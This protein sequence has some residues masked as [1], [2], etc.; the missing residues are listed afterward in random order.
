MNIDTPVSIAIT[1]TCGRIYCL[2]LDR[3]RTER[4]AKNALMQYSQ[5]IRVYSAVIKTVH[6]LYFME[7]KFRRVTEKNQILFISYSWRRVY[8][9]MMFIYSTFF[10]L[11]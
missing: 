5:N 6:W 10:I 9:S 7:F 3:S 8:F 1:Y 11:R 4:S 2:P